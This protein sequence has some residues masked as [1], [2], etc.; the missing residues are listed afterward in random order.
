MIGDDEDLDR[1]V[2]CGEDVEDCVCYVS[3]DGEEYPYDGEEY[4]YDGEVY[5]GEE[6]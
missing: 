5:D 4:A 6:E 2:D 3:Y 1:C